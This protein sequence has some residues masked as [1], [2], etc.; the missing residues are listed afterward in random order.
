M[1]S[2]QPPRADTDDEGS[3]FATPEDSVGNEVVAPTGPVMDNVASSAEGL[4]TYEA[5]SG[6]SPAEDHPCSLGAGPSTVPFRLEYAK[7]HLRPF[8]SHGLTLSR[9]NKSGW[10]SIDPPK[11]KIGIIWDPT[12]GRAEDPLSRPFLDALVEKSK[13]YSP[14]V[15]QCDLS[16]PDVATTLTK[17]SERNGNGWI[18]FGED[19]FKKEMQRYS[20]SRKPSFMFENDSR[21]KTLDFISQ[22]I[23]QAPGARVY[24]PYDRTKYESDMRR[25][26]ANRQV[27]SHRQ[28]NGIHYLQIAEQPRDDTKTTF[29]RFPFFKSASSLR[30]HRDLST[31]RKKSYP[32]DLPDTSAEMVCTGSLISDRTMVVVLNDDEDDTTEM[33]SEELRRLICGDD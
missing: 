11:K 9:T 10:W 31:Q 3:E 22:S 20:E 2:Y 23:C 21:M 32:S 30:R 33:T 26:W 27:L 25:N 14:I 28:E 12:F 6:A 13:T 15:H 18:N 24:Q 7:G 1:S 19:T 16:P 4:H 17:L 5:R 8:L 29:Y